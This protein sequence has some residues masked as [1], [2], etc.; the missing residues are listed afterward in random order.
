M[1]RSDLSSQFSRSDYNRSMAKVYAPSIQEKA[2]AF[3]KGTNGLYMEL[4]NVAF[5]VL[6]FVLYVTELYHPM[7]G[8]TLLKIILERTLSVF[9]LFNLVRFTIKYHM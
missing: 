4:L 8:K 6:L 7:V 2:Q 9:F 3:L 5:S 1:S